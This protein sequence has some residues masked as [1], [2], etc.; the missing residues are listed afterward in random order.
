MEVRSCQSVIFLTSTLQHGKRRQR[1]ADKENE[2]S[3]TVIIVG[4]VEI[5]WPDDQHISVGPGISSTLNMKDLR[6]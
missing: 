2:E 3:D 5:L 4:H 6:S 1:T